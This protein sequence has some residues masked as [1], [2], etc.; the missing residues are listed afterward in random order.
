MGQGRRYTSRSQNPRG[1]A[2][3]SNAIEHST[4]RS[5]DCAGDPPSALRLKNNVG[6]D[7][8]DF[9]YVIKGRSL[10]DGIDT[11]R[12]VF[13]P[14]PVEI[15]A[16]A[17]LQSAMNRQSKLEAAKNFL[18]DMLLDGPRRVKDFKEDVERIAK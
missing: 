1:V 2:I 13:N 18:R 6:D 5:P 4:G 17:L 10:A 15:A 9:S 14:E 16:E 7:R 11:S 12:I 8:T 3:D